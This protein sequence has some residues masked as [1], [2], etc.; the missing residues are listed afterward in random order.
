MRWPWRRR[1]SEARRSRAA[2]EETQREVIE[3]LQDIRRQIRTSGPLEDQHSDL[4]AA[5]IR[6]VI[7]GN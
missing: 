2:S 5:A 6:K 4:F 3:P 1:H 7:R